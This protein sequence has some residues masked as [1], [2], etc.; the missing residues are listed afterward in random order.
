MPLITVM[1]AAQIYHDNDAHDYYD[2]D[3]DKDDDDNDV[4]VTWRVSLYANARTFSAFSQGLTEIGF[5][6]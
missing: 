5:M 6:R 2:A 4:L 3:D 1:G